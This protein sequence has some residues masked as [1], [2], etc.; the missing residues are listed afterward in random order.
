MNTEFK[1]M[2]ELA[3]VKLQE[4]LNETIN[5]FPLFVG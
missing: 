2:Q 4:N 5:D 3:G 1:R